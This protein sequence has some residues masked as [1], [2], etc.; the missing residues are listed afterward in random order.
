MSQRR[1]ALCRNSSAICFM[2]W[3]ALGGHLGA[4]TDRLILT[5]ASRYAMT[6][7]AQVNGGTLS[8]DGGQHLFWNDDTVWV[9]STDQ[10]EV[11]A[12]CPG[13]VRTPLGAA[14]V[15]DTTRADS[16][17][18]EVID[19][20]AGED[21]APRLVRSVGRQCRTETWNVPEPA[22]PLTHAA[23]LWAF[24]TEIPPTPRVK[25][26][27]NRVT[28]SMTDGHTVRPTTLDLPASWSDSVAL[29]LSGTSRVIILSSRLLPFSWIATDDAGRVT[30]VGAIP[31]S[32][33]LFYTYDT[34]VGTGVFAL[35]SG[36]VQVLADLESD[37]RHL[38]IYDSLGA[39]RRRTILDVP[40]GILHTLPH[41]QEL[42]ALRRTDRLEILTYRWSWQSDRA[43]DEL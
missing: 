26:P 3:L 42:L 38:I 4:Q 34:W 18:I 23:G 2:A 17:A 16:V 22:R 37:R 31:T 11:R 28:L 43:K 7:D 5:E 24:V 12:V 19:G 1:G 35:D 13:I 29:V 39:F 6:A 14:F 32:N 40:F 15:R 30:V 36:F 41:R 33:E 9:A 25:P 27:M 21:I 10:S 8:P 20:G